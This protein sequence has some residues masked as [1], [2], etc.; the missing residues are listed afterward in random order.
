M[1]MPSVMKGF[2]RFS[3]MRLAAG[4]TEPFVKVCSHGGSRN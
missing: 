3:L 2:L 1:T 4:N